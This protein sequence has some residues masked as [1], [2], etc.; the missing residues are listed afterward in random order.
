M[1]SAAGCACS[2]PGSRAGWVRS[3]CCQKG[4]VGVFAGLFGFVQVTF[5]NCSPLVLRFFP[6][7]AGRGA[8]V[9]GVLSSL[10]RD[11]RNFL[12]SLCDR[13]THLFSQLLALGFGVKNST[14]FAMR[15]RGFFPEFVEPLVCPAAAAASSQSIPLRRQSGKIRIFSSRL[16]TS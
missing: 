9:P 6:Q 2:P 3:F 13:S 14:T 10:Q 12:L 4:I 1:S 16:S 15:F 11:A 7:G 5:I 8:T